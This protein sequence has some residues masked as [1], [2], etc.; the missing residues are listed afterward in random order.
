MA[1]RIAAIPLEEDDD[2]IEGRDGSAFPGD[3]SEMAASTRSGRLVLPAR[4]PSTARI[5]PV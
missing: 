3:D 4:Q 5:A 1:E 2:L